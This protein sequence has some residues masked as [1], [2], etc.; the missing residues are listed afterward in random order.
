MRVKFTKSIQPYLIR[1]EEESW[2]ALPLPLQV[3]I[4][5]LANEVEQFVG[6]LQLLEYPGWQVNRLE[7]SFG[8][9]SDHF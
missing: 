2:E 8:Y 5:A 7:P 4:E 9:F 6:L 3:I 1:Q